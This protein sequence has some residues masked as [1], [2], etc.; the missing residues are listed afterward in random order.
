MSLLN[1]NTLAFSL[2]D[3]PFDNY[4]EQLDKLSQG[5]KEIGQ[6]AGQGSE[7]FKVASEQIMQC[8]NQG[9]DICTE[10]TNPIKIRAFAIAILGNSFVS[11]LSFKEILTQVNKVIAKPSTLLIGNLC[12]FYLKYYDRIIG[13]DYLRQWLVTAF[14]YRSGRID[15]N[16][17]GGVA[18]LIEF[19]PSWLVE[20]AQSSKRDF[21]NIVIHYGLNYYA[22]GRYMEV[23]KNKYFVEQLKIIPLNAFHPILIEIQ[24]KDTY[25]SQYDRESL[26]GHKVLNI[27]I[28]RAPVVNICKEWFDTVLTIAGD[29]RVPISNLSY[30][31]WWSQLEPGLERKARG[32]FSKLDFKLFLEAL[33]GHANTCQNDELKRMFPSR[34]IFLKGLEEAGLV[35][36][37][38]LYLSN[39]AERYILGTYKK[40]ELPTYSKV[41]GDR[42]MIY[43]N[44]GNKV[45]LVEGSHSCKL[46]IYEKL[47]SSA[48][49]FDYNKSN[50]SYEDLTSD[51]NRKMGLFGC[52]AFGSLTHDIHLN[53]QH[54]AIDGFKLCG[55]FIEPNKLLT[56]ND[57][58]NYRYK[59]GV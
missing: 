32:W 46:W 19:G 25:E 53:W 50:V 22:E 23:A 52:G 6:K 36:D 45:H 33:K 58:R 49:V 27:L 26:L 3:R 37:T 48:V 16:L 39:S 8:L 4:S 14:K 51:L 9:G 47:H 59:F 40:S 10:L 7:K 41:N 13:W 24:K 2:P 30:S 31:K 17:Q 1:L 5:L 29:P 43:I 28:S 11:T 55:I 34:E 20:Q 56:Q 21:D 15:N 57:Y 35:V 18:S 42:S 54:K 44:L 38:R 12:Q